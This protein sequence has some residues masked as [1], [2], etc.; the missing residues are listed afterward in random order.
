MPEEPKTDQPLS[1]NVNT[2]PVNSITS[3]GSK[4]DVEQAPS[5]IASSA[6]FPSSEIEPPT[7]SGIVEET[8]VA[9]PEFAPVTAPPVTA[10]STAVDEALSQ[11][12]TSG[13][14]VSVIPAQQPPK[15]GGKKKFIIA[16]VIV[17]VLAL[18][19]GG[20]VLAYNIWN[21]SPD[22]VIM[23]GLT[24]L[25]TKAPKSTVLTANYENNGMKVALSADVKSSEQLNDAKI[26]VSY[27]D[28]KE[29]IDLSASANVVTKSQ[30]GTVYL[31]LNDIREPI[32]KIINKFARTQ[33]AAAAQ[34]GVDVEKMRV[35]TER[36]LLKQ[37][38]PIIAKVESKWIK[39]A[40]EKGSSTADSE[41]QTC[42]NNLAKKIEND[43]A[44]QNELMKAYSDNKFIVVKE[45]L[46]VKD[47][48]YGYVLGF[49]KVKANTFVKAIDSTQFAKSLSHC[50]G[51]SHE[52]SSSIGDV[53]GVDENF[54]DSRFELWVSQDS[55]Q[56][57]AVNAQATHLDNGNESKVKLGV[58]FSYE[59]VQ[60]LSEPTDAVDGKALFQ[61]IQMLFMQNM[62]GGGSMNTSSDPTRSW[63][64]SL[65]ETVINNYRANN[66]G[67]QPTEAEV[68][69]MLKELG[70]T[71]NNT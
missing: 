31:K 38:S 34:Q 45:Q 35:D 17:G 37:A 40:A 18:L 3:D 33:A 47:G 24:N 59:P 12:N 27:A 61:E 56:I 68:Q 58:T 49:D 60:A 9:A 50:L 55:H 48:S 20:G 43:K 64:E 25:L 15:K 62:M 28:S 23:D 53:S 4:I 54:K 10:F 30:D 11:P 7:G 6:V 41:M 66:R 42:L 51:A 16:G 67:K 5:Q 13:E 52:S 63:E 19:G 69:K 14:Q 1:P 39:I 36:E 57:T 26:T 46:G 2:E 32:E 70:A 8:S 21:Q 44:T 29:A 22:K 71:P 65:K